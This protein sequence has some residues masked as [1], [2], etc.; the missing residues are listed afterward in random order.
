MLAFQL[1]RLLSCSGLV[2]ALNARLLC[3]AP[4]VFDSFL[5]EFKQSQLLA[6]TGT[7]EPPIARSSV[8]NLS[9]SFQQNLLGERI[10]FDVSYA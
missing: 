6:W 10:G 3:L 4:R 8:D 2:L 7:G 9:D 1:S 5:L